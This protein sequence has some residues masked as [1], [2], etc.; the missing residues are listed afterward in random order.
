M[1]KFACRPFGDIEVDL[2]DPKTYDHLP[3]NL[4]ELRT[5]MLSEIGYA[6]CYMNFWHKDIFTEYSAGRGQKK[7]VEALVKNFTE[8]ERPNYEN[9]LWYQEQIFLFQDEKENMC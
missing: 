3:K 2:D 6:Y 7:R 5:K 4:N 8:N 1:R 9:T